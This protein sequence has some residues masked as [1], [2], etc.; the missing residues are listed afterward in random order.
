MSKQN[1]SGT[2]AVIFVGLVLVAVAV[3]IIKWLLIT[4]AILAVPFGLWWCIDYAT[5]SR[6]ARTT[7]EPQ[8]EAGPVH[9][10]DGEERALP[11]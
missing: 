4:A 5:R 9:L 1:N 2:G 6:R 8:A 10:A 3:L 11:R 7:Q